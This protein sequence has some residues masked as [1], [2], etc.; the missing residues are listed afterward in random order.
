MKLLLRLREHK[1]VSCLHLAWHVFTEFEGDEN[2][3]FLFSLPE[4][5]PMG[6]D[7]VGTGAC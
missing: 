7:R 4:L 5:E 2:V 6:K 3:T 1:Q